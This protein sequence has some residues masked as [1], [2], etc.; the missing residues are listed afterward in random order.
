[1]SHPDAPRDREVA[2]G[3]GAGRWVAV[4]GLGTDVPSEVVTGAEIAARSGVPEEVVVE[5]MGVREKRV[6]GPDDR[7]GDDGPFFGYRGDGQGHFASAPAVEDWDE[8]E[9]KHSKD[10]IHPVEWFDP[11]HLPQTVEPIIPK[12]SCH[13]CVD[14]SPRHPTD[15]R[16]P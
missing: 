3:P 9:E 4:T 13:T 5:K 14:D 1:M 8:S 16:S 7:L 11:E 6:A 15:N 12:N 2:D 10:D